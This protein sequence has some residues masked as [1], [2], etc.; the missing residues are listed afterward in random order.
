VLTHPETGRRGLYVNA[1]FTTH[2]IGMDDEESR[3]LLFALYAHCAQDEYHTTLKWR[4]GTVAMWDNR[5]TWHWA[6]N[7]YHGQ[8]RY[9][10][11][12]TVKG[13]PLR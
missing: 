8:R 7:D 12:I 13:V 11:R 3:A 4:P 9:M 2:I 10:H 5:S 1:A 6:L